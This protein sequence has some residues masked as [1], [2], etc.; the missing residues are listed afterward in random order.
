MSLCAG[1]RSSSFTRDTKG[2][3]GSDGVNKRIDGEWK[4]TFFQVLDKFQEAEDPPSPQ[5]SWPPPPSASPPQRQDP[6]RRRGLLRLIPG[7]KKKQ[8]E[9]RQPLMVSTITDDLPVAGQ[10]MTCG[11][12]SA[13]SRCKCIDGT[14][15]YV[16]LAT[17]LFA[18]E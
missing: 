11:A 8:Q 1:A 16:R 2:L 10:R 14:G 13:G 5:A 6:R 7:G 18:N 15:V 9:E 3:L 4:E 17:T 12:F